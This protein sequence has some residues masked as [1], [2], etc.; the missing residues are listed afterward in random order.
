MLILLN[1]IRIQIHGGIA[2]FKFVLDLGTIFNIFLLIFYLV[3][4]IS[5]QFCKIGSWGKKQYISKVRK[6]MA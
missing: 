3:I 2:M 6:N 1:L 4:A 5:F